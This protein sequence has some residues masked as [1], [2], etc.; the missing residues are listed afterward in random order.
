PAKITAVVMHR[1]GISLAPSRIGNY[2]SKG[3]PSNEI[4]SWRVDSTGVSS[5]KPLPPLA[6]CGS[7]RCGDRSTRVRR[8]E[9]GRRAAAALHRRREERAHKGLHGPLRKVTSPPLK[10]PPK[11][12][13]PPPPPES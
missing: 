6:S 11:P 9:H 13:S 3:T 4:N 10:L 5:R 1:P 8:H 2:S 7:C 12:Q